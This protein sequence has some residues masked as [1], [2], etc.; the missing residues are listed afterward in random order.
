[1]GIHVWVPS[2]PTSECLLVLEKVLLSDGCVVASYRASVDD[3]AHEDSTL[4]HSCS[5]FSLPPFLVHEELIALPVRLVMLSSARVVKQMGC[6][7]KILK[8]CT[9]IELNYC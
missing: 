5:C 9:F 6:A 4:C 2:V 1:L 3:S 8:V 7:C